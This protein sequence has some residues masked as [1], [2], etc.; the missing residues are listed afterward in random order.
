[1]VRFNRPVRREGDH[2]EVDFTEAERALVSSLTA[3]MRHLVT[4]D[5][6][7]VRRLFPPPYGDDAERNAGY[8]ALA[9]TELVDRRLEALDVVE[10]TIEATELSEDELLAWM[11][12]L[13]DVRLVLG[14]ILDVSEE[15]PLVPHPDAPETAAAYEYLGFLLEVVVEAFED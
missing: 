7:A 6:T 11:R 8:D 5:S 15:A 10:R 1:M 12:S 9:G 4:S 3:Q 2:F 14:T 13:N